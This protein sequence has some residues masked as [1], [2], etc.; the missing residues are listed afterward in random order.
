MSGYYDWGYNNSYNYGGYNNYYG[1]NNCCGYNNCNYNCCG[2]VKIKDNTDITWCDKPKAFLC[3]PGCTKR[4]NKK[5]DGCV[6]FCVTSINN[7]FK[8]TFTSHSDN[9]DGTEVTHR[10]SY[11]IDTCC[12]SSKHSV[13]VG[14]VVN[15]S[16][17]PTLTWDKCCNCLIITLTGGEPSNTSDSSSS[18]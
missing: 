16:K 10:V 13:T 1:Y 17:P 8:L 5:K 2:T 7:C 18:S 11:T 6:E 9:D 14:T 3:P 4:F 12:Q 15:W